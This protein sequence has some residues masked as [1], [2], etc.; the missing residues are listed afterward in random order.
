MPDMLKFIPLPDF[1]SLI[2][3]DRNLIRE[4]ACSSDTGLITSE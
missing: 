2:P 4:A 3:A 1:L